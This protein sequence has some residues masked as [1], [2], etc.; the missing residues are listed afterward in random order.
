MGQPAKRVERPSVNESCLKVLF[1]WDEVHTSVSRRMGRCFDLRRATIASHLRYVLPDVPSTVGPCPPPKDDSNAQRLMGITTSE[2]S[3][4]MNMHGYPIE[5]TAMKMPIWLS[6]VCPA[7][8]MRLS[9][10]CGNQTR[11]KQCDYEGTPDAPPHV[12]VSFLGRQKPS[13]P[14][15]PVNSNPPTSRP[16]RRL[17][18]RQARTPRRSGGG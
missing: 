16:I 5:A 2:A 12:G 4:R 3:I 17:G 18:L 10:W 9:R 8:A 7:A 6:G 14:P 11:Q 15:Q 13:T 1:A